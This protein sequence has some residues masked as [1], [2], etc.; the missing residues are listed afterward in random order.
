MVLYDQNKL[1]DEWMLIGI[2]SK[3]Q[4]NEIKKV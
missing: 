3:L 1:F 2:Y 4:L